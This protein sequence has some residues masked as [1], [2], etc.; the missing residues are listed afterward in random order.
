[1][2]R[3]A[4]LGAGCA[5]LLLG[6][7]Q[8]M[9]DDPGL[10]EPPGLNAMP[11]KDLPEQALRY[12]GP[13]NDEVLT[14]ISQ[15]LKIFQQVLDI[16]SWFTGNSGPT[17]QDLMN[18][19]NVIISQNAEVRYE[20]DQ[21][22]SQLSATRIQLQNMSGQ[23]VQIA[24]DA[25]LANYSERALTDVYTSLYY[26]GQGTRDTTLEG[27]SWSEAK[28]AADYFMQSGFYYVV[29]ASGGY[30]WTPEYAMLP[31]VRSIGVEI[32][33]ARSLY[34]QTYLSFSNVKP[35]LCSNYSFV[36]ALA[37]QV[38]AWADA[39]CIVGTSSTCV[40]MDIDVKPPRCSRR[41]YSYL[42]SC[43][44]T[45]F[46]VSGSGYA[47]NTDARNAGLAAIAP[48]VV[49][50]EAMAGYPQLL[51]LTSKLQTVVGSCP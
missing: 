25:E 35:A 39:K 37:P 7:G 33:V 6:C 14:T 29:S 44:G 3:R 30:T 40:E 51:A 4:W 10:G 36:Q 24:V 45:T 27:L 26:R 20:I 13:Q 17:N 38:K 19:L 18:Q 2:N 41:D 32:E 15:G 34:P 48:Y 31:L 28:A 47:T 46:R 42:G 50:T 8:G 23:Q 21:V 11:S 43:S 49:Q 12:T 1:M 5:L 9:V 22:L 16:V